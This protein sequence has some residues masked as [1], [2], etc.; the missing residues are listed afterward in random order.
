MPEKLEVQ[1]GTLSLMILRT[2]DVLGA[3]HGYSAPVS[4]DVATIGFRQHIAATQALR[5]GTYSKT[6]TFTLST[7]TP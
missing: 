1:Q 2:L 5:T 3:L 6:L 7:A 4:N